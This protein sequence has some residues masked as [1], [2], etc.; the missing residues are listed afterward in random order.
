MLI[1]K[2]LGCI[3]ESRGPPYIRIS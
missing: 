2:C 1:Q 3:R